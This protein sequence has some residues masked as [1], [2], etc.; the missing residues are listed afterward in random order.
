MKIFILGICGTFMGG[1]AS[2]AKQAGFDV[3]GCDADVYPPMSDM[4]KN[5]GVTLYSGYDPAHLT[6]ASPDLVIIGNALSRGNLCVEKVLDDKLPY[7]SGPQWL[8][9]NI[10][11]HRHVLAVA[12]T[13]GKTTTTAI[14]TWILTA[15]GYNPGYLIGGVANN[16]PTSAK[17]GE[18]PYFVIE[19]DEYDT[20]F[21]DKRPKFIHYH[22]DT[23][24]A[25]NLE[26]DHADIYPDLMSIERQFHYLIRTVPRQG[27]II[28]PA[29]DVALNRTI[30]QGCWSSL[31][32]FG[33]QS[34][35]WRAQPLT[36]DASEFAIFHQQQCLGKVKWSLFGAHN[37]LNAL[38]AIIAA[39]KVGISVQAA[40]AALP[41]FKGIKRRLELRGVSNSNI[42]VYDDFAHHPTAI[43]KTIEAL[44]KRV[45]DQRIMAIV[46]FGS[47]SMSAGIH[48]L[49]LA[50]SLQLAD[51]V[52]LA[53]PDGVA[54]DSSQ[55]LANMS[56]PA[57]IEFDVDTM[58]TKIK[59]AARPGDHILIMSNKAFGGIHQKLLVQLGSV[60]E[61]YV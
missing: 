42:S 26:F 22:P 3:S 31:N 49:D 32:F 47:N 16:F 4:L 12:G 29:G 11:R 56:Q 48:V 61:S 33:E 34:G 44:R 52:M 45:G 41:E 57:Y 46:H 21:F 35:D 30:A 39:S 10:L 36:A 24:I 14:L 8:A 37:M 23:L 9:E 20:A 2:I 18:N 5:L 1:I 25:N 59:Q 19:A 7:L 58:V 27:E 6:A 15:N 40:I 55:L 38:A 60:G 17:I 28:L 13:H 53:I 50:D 43:K 54:W 51:W